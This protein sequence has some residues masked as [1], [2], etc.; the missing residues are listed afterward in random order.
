VQRGKGIDKYPLIGVSIVAVILLILGSLT[1]VVGY[2]AIQSSNQKVIN[3][4][5]GQKDLLFQTIIDVANNGE[6]QKI[7]FSSEM[8]GGVFF[9][10]GMRFSVFTPQVITKNY[11]NSAYRIGLVLTKALGVSRMHSILERYQVHNQ[12]MQKDITAIIQ[13]NATLAREIKQLSN[14]KCDCENISGVTSWPFPVICL[15]IETLTLIALAL[16]LR[17]GTYIR[18]ILVEIGITLINIFHCTG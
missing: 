7:V 14:S 1:N 10:T 12:G 6:I 13:K 16:F 15:I 17:Y 11:L 5:V 8:Q 18:Y 3:D 2:Q 9:N 4:E